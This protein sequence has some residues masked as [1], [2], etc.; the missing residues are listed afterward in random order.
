MKQGSSSRRPRGRNNNKRQS[1]NN[2][3]DSSGPEGRVRGNARQVY[4][5][6]LTM[7]S[8]A[9]MV[10]DRIASENYYQHAEHYYRIVNSQAA[11]DAEKEGQKDGNN[12]RNRRH[13]N[14]NRNQQQGNGAEQQHAEGDNTSDH[15]QGEQPALAAQ[16]PEITPEHVVV[17]EKPAESATVELN[18]DVDAIVKD[19]DTATA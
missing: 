18:G 8:D 11:A 5:K 2:N 6:Y 19:T 9:L 15:G 14:N 17:E 1:R 4:E 10:D 3:F 16:Q 13:N 12:N 7:A